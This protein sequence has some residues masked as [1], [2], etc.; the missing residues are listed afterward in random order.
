MNRSIPLFIVPS[1]G[2]S[3]LFFEA[4]LLLPSPPPAAGARLPQRREVSN[5]HLNLN[6]SAH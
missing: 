6:L 4:Y 3:E 1:Y 5:N 2:A